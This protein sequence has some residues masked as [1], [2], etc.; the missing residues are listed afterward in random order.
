MVNILE[1]KWEGLPYVIS[2][3]S[4]QQRFRMEFPKATLDKVANKQIFICLA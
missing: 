1:E 2:V 3:A 4:A